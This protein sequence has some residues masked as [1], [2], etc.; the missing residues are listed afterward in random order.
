MLRGGGCSCFA[1]LRNSFRR[2]EDAIEDHKPSVVLSLERYARLDEVPSH[3]NPR[4]GS[5]A[6]PVPNSPTPWGTWNREGSSEALPILPDNDAGPQS[7][8]NFTLFFTEEGVR[9]RVDASPNLAAAKPGRILEIGLGTSRS[10]GSPKRT[11]AKGAPFQVEQLLSSPGTLPHGRTAAER[12][13]L[14]ETRV[15][16]I[17]AA[18]PKG[19]P[20]SERIAKTPRRLLVS[21]Q[22]I[23]QRLRRGLIEGATIVFFTAGYEGKRF[24]YEKAKSLG[25]RSILID[26][27]GS[28]SERLVDEG[29]IIKFIALDMSLSSQEVFEHALVAIKQCQADPEVGKIDGVVTFAELSV[30]I[31]ARLAEALGLPGHIPESADCARDKH[32]TRAA[33]ARAGLPTPPNCAINCEADLEKA[34]KIVGLPAVLKPVSGAASV[35][36]KKV[37]T[38]EELRSAYLERAQ[39]LRSLVVRNGSIVKDDG[40]GGAVVNVTDLL[41]ARFLLEAYLDGDEVDVDIV[42]SEG[43]WQFAAVADNGPTL[44]PYFNETWAVSPSLLPRHKQV[45]LKELAINAIKALGFEDGIFH[46][47][48]KYTSNCGPQLIE[49]NARMGGGPVFVTNLRT[50]GIDLVEETFFCA[51]GIPARPPAR[52]E[53]LEC[54]ANTDV[55]TLRSGKLVDLA[56]LE[57]LKNRDG[58]VSYSNHV[59]PG[60]EV[61]GPSEGLPTWLVEIVVSKPTPREALDFL[62]ELEAEVQKKVNVVTAGDRRNGF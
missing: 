21:R 13:A 24:I 36:V 49:V 28:W 62:L 47:E 6:S 10:P 1:W 53:P 61:V 4:V 52:R 23:G 22:P 25:I 31:A 34:L 33:L 16:E 42:M 15:D 5:W 30:P 2:F 58:V 43:E 57:P 45:A 27:E 37:E 50:W 40:E 26:S 51:V 18:L 3:E 48:L 14:N 20:T 17:L 8:V 41:G 46:V 11:S 60:E 38:E 12:E 32:A 19:V 35:G 7:P 55:N 29:V 54:I 9:P 56:F 39:E 59:R 44:E